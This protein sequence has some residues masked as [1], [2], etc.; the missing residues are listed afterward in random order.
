MQMAVYDTMQI[1]I[2]NK[3]KKANA[4]T[5][6][7]FLYISDFQFIN[8]LTTINFIDISFMQ[9]I[10]KFPFIFSFL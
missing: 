2:K 8:M 4:H 1:K 9:K 3:R 5:L 6:R 7:K 10:V